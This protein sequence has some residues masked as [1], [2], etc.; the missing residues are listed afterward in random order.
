[1]IYDEIDLFVYVNKSVNSDWT[2]SFIYV[3]THIWHIF[4]FTSF[5]A[6]VNDSRILK[7]F[8][9]KPYPRSKCVLFKNYFLDQNSSRKSKSYISTDRSL[10]IYIYIRHV[11]SFTKSMT[12]F[13]FSKRNIKRF[14]V[15]CTSVCVSVWC[16]ILNS[17]SNR[18][19]N[20]KK[21]CVYAPIRLNI[22]EADLWVSVEVR[23]NVFV[24]VLLIERQIK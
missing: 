2:L 16:V 11:W 20:T 7:R 12:G 10:Y 14:R 22:Y 6:V 18:K 5:S 13:L 17:Q 1:L 24:S 19:I 3:H 21:V 4:F 9:V 23:L 8:F 15:F